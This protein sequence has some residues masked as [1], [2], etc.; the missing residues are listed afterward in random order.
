MKQGLILLAVSIVCCFSN[1]CR[2]DRADEEL[3]WSCANTKTVPPRAT[4]EC[5]KEIETGSTEI[6]KYYKAVP[7]FEHGKIDYYAMIS[8]DHRS[9]KKN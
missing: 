1:S 3:N 5:L 9:A 2:N 8:N 6:L 4:P 7:H